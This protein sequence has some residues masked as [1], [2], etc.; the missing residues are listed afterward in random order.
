M[1]MKLLRDPGLPVPDP[2]DADWQHLPHKHL[3]N[4]K[5]D[6]LPV[7]LI[8][9]DRVARLQRQLKSAASTEKHVR[10]LL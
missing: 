8:D 10:A 3:A 9:S 2:I 7:Y 5:S 1:L 6:R 4:I